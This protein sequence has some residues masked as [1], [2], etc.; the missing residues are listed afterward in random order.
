VGLISCSTAS[1]HHTPQACRVL[2]ATTRESFY[3]RLH[4]GVQQPS[5]VQGHHVDSDAMKVEL[6]RKGLNI[7]LQDH[8]V[9]NLNLSYNDLASTAIDQEGTMRACEVTEEKK[10]Q[11]TTP[12]PT[13]GSSSSAPPKYRMVYT[14]PVGQLRRPLQFRGNRQQSQLQQQQYTHAPFTLQHQGAARPP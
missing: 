12:R 1:G 7:Y 6:Y 2:G 8:L 9:Q 13:R 10:R 14:P 4:L 3:V 5:T 11:T